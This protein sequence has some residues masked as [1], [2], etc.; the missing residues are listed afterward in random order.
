MDND[1]VDFAMQCPVNFK[2]NNLADVVR[3]NENQAGDKQGQF[4]Q[5]TK[6]GKQILRDVMRN[7]IPDEIT[8]AAKQGFSAPDNSWFKGESIDFVRRKL[9]TDNARIFEWMDRTTVR[10]LVN[11]HLTGQQN[12]RLLIWSLLNFEQTLET[13]S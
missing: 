11:E 5:K 7:Y 6:D 12:R 4:F 8:K 1:L 9:L 13:L 10:S 3:I 2:L